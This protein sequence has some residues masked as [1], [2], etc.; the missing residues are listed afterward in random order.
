MPN[1]FHAE[2]SISER[3]CVRYVDFIGGHR[4][5]PLS[6][7]EELDEVDPHD[8]LQ[9]AHLLVTLSIPAALDGRARK[10][11]FDRL[12][13]GLCE[14]AYALHYGFVQGTFVDRLTT[15]IVAIARVVDVV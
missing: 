7:L 9:R 8:L 5:E 11:R 6:M 4:R 3:A 13:G 10:Q 1:W 14:R 15:R 12:D 2:D